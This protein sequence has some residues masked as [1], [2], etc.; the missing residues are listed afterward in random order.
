MSLK[1][2]FKRIV[3][4]NL[5]LCKEIVAKKSHPSNDDWLSTL[6]NATEGSSNHCDV[7]LLPQDQDHCANTDPCFMEFG[8]EILSQVEVT[9][10]SSHMKRNESTV[11]TVIPLNVISEF[12]SRNQN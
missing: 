8:F 2:M 6:L 7:L 11:S 3:F 4:F 12:Q 1:A 9:K 10:Y 5:F